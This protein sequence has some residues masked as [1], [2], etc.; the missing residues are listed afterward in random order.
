MHYITHPATPECESLTLLH[1]T[2]THSL[3]QSGEPTCRRKNVVVIVCPHFSPDPDGPNYDN[4]C[5]QK[6]MLHTPFRVEQELLDGHDTFI[7]AYAYYLQTGN[8]PP[9]HEDDIHRLAEQHSQNSDEVSDHAE[10][11]CSVGSTMH[12]QKMDA[13][14][15]APSSTR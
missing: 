3:S 12:L 4:Y 2:Q 6:L 13:H 9:C 14:L 8:I 1:F 11:E 5:R 7:E 10:V 15:S